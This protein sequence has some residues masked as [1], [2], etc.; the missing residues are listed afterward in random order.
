MESKVS[1]ADQY[2]VMSSSRMRY[3]VAAKHVMEIVASPD[4][5]ALPQQPAYL[6]GIMSYKGNMIPVISLRAACGTENDDKEKVCVILKIDGT[7]LA[8]TV[9]GARSLISD[10]GQRMQVDESL[11]SGRLLKL[12]FVVPGDPA[13]FVIDGKRTYQAIEKDFNSVSAV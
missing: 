2:L 7:S 5:T 3:A 4:V 1:S 8:I 6:R 10:S 9:D 13:T 11:M 12:D